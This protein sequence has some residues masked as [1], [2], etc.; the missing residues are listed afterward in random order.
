MCREAEPIPNL[1]VMARHPEVRPQFLLASVS[2]LMI[3]LE[4]PFRRLGT[5]WWPV[6]LE[7]SPEEV[8]AE[9][10]RRRMAPSLL[11]FAFLRSEGWVVREEVN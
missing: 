2:L 11:S 7:V 10:V 6:T 8:L 4:G 9:K 5:K 3:V 1:L